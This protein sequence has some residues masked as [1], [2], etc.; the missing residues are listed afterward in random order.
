MSIHQF[1]VKDIDG[2]D[3][4]LE[5]YIGKVVCIVNV[6]SRWGKTD[7]NYKQFA[8]LTKKYPQVASVTIIHLNICNNF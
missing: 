5:K 4:S 7:V 1:T 8:E 3:V 2:A 6:A